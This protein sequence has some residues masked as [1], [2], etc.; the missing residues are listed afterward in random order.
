MSV[1]KRHARPA[2]GWAGPPSPPNPL[3]H[4]DGRGGEIDLGGTKF[5]PRPRIAAARPL[6]DGHLPLSAIAMG[7]GVGGEG[8]PGEPCREVRCRFRTDTSPCQIAMGEGVGGEGGPR[9]PSREMRCR[10]PTDTSP[11]QPDRREG[12]RRRRARQRAGCR[13]VAEASGGRG[14]SARDA[15]G[16]RRPR[17]AGRAGR[18][19]PG[20]GD[21]RA[22]GCS[23][24]R[25]RGVRAA[26]LA[27]LVVS[28]CRRAP[29]LTKRGVRRPQT[30]R[31]RAKAR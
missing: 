25:R 31:T 26:K 16:Q 9:G 30:P 3:S 8:G 24:A 22:V 19:R 29:A 7:E 17:P 15:P 20:L 4:G 1:R 13:R 28:R 6:P 10:F 21:G 11:C 14:G 2:A 18:A 23:R 27:G 5:P 12:A